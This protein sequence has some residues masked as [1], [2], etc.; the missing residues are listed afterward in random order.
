MKTTKLR[1]LRTAM[2]ASLLTLM[3]G[4]CATIQ[5]GHHHSTASTQPGHSAQNDLFP[6]NARPGECYARVIIPAAYKTES[7]KVL[8]REAGSKVD[9]IPA[10]YG[11]GQEKVLVRE[12]STR[13]EVVPAVYGAVTERV[14]VKPQRTRL[15]EVP[16]RYTTVTEK[17]LD[18]PARTEWKRG[19]GLGKGQGVGGG[20]SNV[21]NRFGGNQVLETRVEDTGEV[22][23]LVEIPATYKTV[24]KQK[25]VS[26]ATTRK[27][28]IPAEYK[29]VTRRVVK[30]PATT[31]EIRIPA[32]YKTVA[33]T[34]V[35]QPEKQRVTKTPAEYKTVTHKK[36]VRDERLEWRPVLCE[37]N[38]TQE[39]VRALQSSLAAEGCYKCSV[40]GIMGPC[41]VKAA[42]CYAKPRGLPFGDKYI[43]L[44]VIRSLGL[45]F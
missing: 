37:V 28:V 5:N 36:K 44:E 6:P 43:T 35:V 18:Q 12:A 9:I 16:A 42:Q 30:K 27:E 1:T 29:T 33:T 40:D 22:M 32:E 45:R 25:L 4:G 26:P 15:V 2:A 34:K 38:M 8:V 13:I 41:T 21:V 23:C 17:V 39:N 14:L 20:A 31:R 7:E 10:V 19:T 24:T 3:L 11:T